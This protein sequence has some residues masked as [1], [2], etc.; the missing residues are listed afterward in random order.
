[1]TFCTA[2]NCLDGRVQEP[3][4]AFL[5]KYFG[6][7][8]V[9]MVTEAGPV[10]Y[11]GEP[12]GEITASILKRVELTIIRH[13]PVGIA[14]TAHYDCLGNPVSEETQKR[15]LKDAAHF[16][17]GKFP[18]ETIETFWVDSNWQVNIVD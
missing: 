9:D 12:Q 16:L 15:Q 5:K 4:V 11:L 17:R 6:V 18:G 10:Q 14:V 7:K 8:Y 1:M 3:V 13:N 2:I